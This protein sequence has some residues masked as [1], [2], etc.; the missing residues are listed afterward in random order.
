MSSELALHDYQIVAK[1]FLRKQ[2]RAALF[3]DMPP[4]ASARP[5]SC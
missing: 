3:L 5:L 4:S 1:D 2:D